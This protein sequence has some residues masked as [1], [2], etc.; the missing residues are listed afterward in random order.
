MTD[1]LHELDDRIFVLL[2][3]QMYIF[4]F[5]MISWILSLQSVPKYV[6]I[7]V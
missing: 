3:K 1:L 6:K 4:I 2:N 5:L 7:K